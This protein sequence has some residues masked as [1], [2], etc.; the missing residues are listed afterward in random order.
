[1]ATRRIAHGVGSL[2]VADEKGIEISNAFLPALKDGERWVGRVTEVRRDVPDAEGVITCD[3]R[4]L[5]R[6]VSR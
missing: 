3:V 6:R 2:G 5:Y 4:V 1:M